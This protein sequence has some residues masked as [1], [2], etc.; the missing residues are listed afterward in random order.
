MYMILFYTRRV[1][2]FSLSSPVLI[3]QLNDSNETKLPEN[4]NLLLNFT[5][6]EVQY[7]CSCCQAASK[8]L[9]VTVTL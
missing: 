4:V 3:V 9:H 2:E 1:G 7:V 5:V 8:M 6:F